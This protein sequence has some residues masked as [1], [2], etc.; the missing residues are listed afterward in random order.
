MP[1]APKP[2]VTNFPA[3]QDTGDYG[4]DQ[5]P[6]LTDDSELGANDGDIV[7]VTHVMAL[8]NKAQAL[9]RKI[10]DNTKAPFGSLCDILDTVNNDLPT[11]AQQLRLLKRS[12]APSSVANKGFLYTK[13]YTGE[14]TNLEL[15]YMDAGGQEVR[16][17]DDGNVNAGVGTLDR[18]L[19]FS[20]DTEFSEAGTGWTT[21][22]QFRY[23]MDLTS[24]SAPSS[25]R[26]LANIWVEGGNG[27]TDTVECQLLF[28]WGETG[29]AQAI[30]TSTNNYALQLPTAITV[31]HPGTASWQDCQIRLRMQ[32]GSSGV[33]HIDYT[34]LFAIH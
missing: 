19:M 13:D 15:Y 32:S 9:A 30:G 16:L 8:R 22:K 10:G 7:L 34:D 6:D 1:L 4:K 2:W 14:T 23:L 26:L 24:G 11:D 29:T 28:S 18:Y 27:T 5:M 3:V 21:K 20:D 25:F 17:T 31:V 33:A 12:A